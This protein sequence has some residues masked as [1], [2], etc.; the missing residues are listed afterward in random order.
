M[1]KNP[2]LI[3]LWPGVSHHEEGFIVGNKEGIRML[4]A[5]LHALLENGGPEA[6]EVM[7]SDG[8]GYTLHLI[9]TGNLT[10]PPHGREDDLAVP[11]TR[12]GARETRE[13]AVFPWDMIK[14][15]KDI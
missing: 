11:Y 1:G 13:N 4:Q 3:H 2:P 5:Y 6:I 12:E 8:E 10:I 7:T 9:C 15:G 14:G